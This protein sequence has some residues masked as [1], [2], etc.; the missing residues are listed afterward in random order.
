MLGEQ[1]LVNLADR[2]VEVSGVVGVVL[3]GSRARGEHTGDSDV[4]LGLYYRRPLDVDALSALARELAGP[5]AQ[6]TQPGA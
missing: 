3:G 4:D 6:V 1:R 2:V 5:G